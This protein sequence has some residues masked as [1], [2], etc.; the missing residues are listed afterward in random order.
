MAAIKKLKPNGLTAASF[1]A[2]IGG[3]SLGWRMAGYDVVYANEFAPSAA[4]TY[5]L[6][7]SPSTK[8]DRTDVHEVT[9]ASFP[10]VPGHLDAMDGS[11]PCTRFSMSGTQQAARGLGKEKVYAHGAKQKDEDLFPEFVRLRD[12]LMP[13]TFVA[14]NV[15]G[16]VKGAAKG[17]FLDTLA[18]LRRGYR[19]QVYLLDAQW[20]GVPQ[21]RERLFF[22]GVRDDLDLEPVC[23]VPRRERV[24]VAEALADPPADAVVEPE[25]DISR[26]AIGREWDRLIAGQHST[27]YFNLHKAHLSEPCQ[28]ITASA[29]DF[30]SAASVVHPT[31]KRKFAIWELKRL[32]S[33]PDDF[34]M[35]GTYAEQYR[36]LGNSVPPLMMSEVAKALRDRVLL[37]AR[38]A[39]RT[40]GPARRSRGSSRND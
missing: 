13:K 7:V 15:P 37:P 16:L 22:V 21:R 10:L 27:R 36:G 4:A 33:F 28:T 8:L 12:A 24:S 3:S 38:A 1:F 17:Y 20:L 19:V 14:E 2:G 26:Y 29:G 34:L 31:E 5:S 25:T 32:C 39:A 9:A 30:L 40:A 6:N 35:A 11:A 18:A 23:P